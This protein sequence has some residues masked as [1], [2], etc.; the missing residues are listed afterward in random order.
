MSKYSKNISPLCKNI[1]DCKKKEIYN[2][3]EK[4]INFCNSLQD[5][6]YFLN[7]L[8]DIFKYLKLYKL[9]K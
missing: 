5:V 4:K 6:E 8:K 7:N 3:E 2:I 1:S 9:L